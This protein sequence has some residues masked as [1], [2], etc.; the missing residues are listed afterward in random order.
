MSSLKQYH[1][2]DT[3][4]FFACNKRR[5]Y[6]QTLQECQQFFCSRFLAL[7]KCQFA[8]FDSASFYLPPVSKFCSDPEK[9]TFINTVE[10]R[11]EKSNP[12]LKIQMNAKKS[13]HRSFFSE[14]R[15]FFLPN[16][17]K[18]DIIVVAAKGGGKS[19]LCCFVSRSVDFNRPYFFAS[20]MTSSISSRAF[21]LLSLSKS[22]FQ[23]FHAVTFN[24]YPFLLTNWSFRGI[25]GIKSYVHLRWLD[26]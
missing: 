18:R 13:L 2:K 6:L 21:S 10:K 15:D 11:V 25:I 7:A 19:A 12:L 8:L 20:L 3:L 5:L 17:T 24:N 22:A 1:N 16:R 23:F 4:L 26:G 14:C 9:F